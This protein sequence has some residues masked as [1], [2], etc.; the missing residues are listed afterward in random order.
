[1]N[2]RT[3]SVFN[4]SLW[5]LVSLLSFILALVTVYLQAQHGAW[6]MHILVD[7]YFAF[8]DRAKFFLTHGNLTNVPFNE[9]QPGAIFYFVSLSPILLW[10]DTREIYIQTLI[11]S[12][13]FLL[14]LFGWAL[15][16]RF[17]AY[18][19]V[20]L[21]LIALSA[22]PLILF[23]FEVY[24]HLLVFTGYLLWQR[25]KSFF[26]SFF[27]G[28]ATLVKVYPVVVLPYFMI[29]AFKEHGWQEAAKAVAGYVAGALTVL[30]LY[31]AVFQVPVSDVIKN[32]VVH[33]DKPV[34]VESVIGSLNALNVWVTEQR[35]AVL[36]SRLIHGIHAKELVGPVSLYNYFWIPAVG[37]IYL[38]IWLSEDK[39][40]PLDPRWPLLIIATLLVTATQLGPQY[41]F[42]FAFFF[43]LIAFP[44]TLMEQRHY[45]V[46]LFLLLLLF[47]FTQ[48]VYPLHYS[49][50]LNYFR[51]GRPL[52]PFAYMMVK[53]VIFIAFVAHFM[54]W[55]RSSQRQ[56][57]LDNR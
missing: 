20:V 23:R 45:L 18:S 51:D 27:L 47:F 54:Y 10:E 26:A 2:V 24:C 19:P 1:M 42:W 13:I 46:S 31:L 38:W 40:T 56:R 35:P 41:F 52:F 49:E 21:A 5:P 37:L 57:L 22:G 3:E 17:W 48:F 8:Y 50:L 4:A 11:W 34:H 36:D 32:V 30:V 14:S 16:K 29:R 44:K 7:G 33:A 15:R 6:K 55:M 39:K 53:N 12:N 9:Y 43:P 25:Q 28:A